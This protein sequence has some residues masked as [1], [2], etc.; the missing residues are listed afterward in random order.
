MGKTKK[1]ILFIVEGITDKTALGAVLDA[2]LSNEKIHFAITE[3]DITTKDDVNASNVIRRINEI[4]KFTQ[5]RYHFKASDLLEVVHLIDT[6]GAFISDDAVIDNPD[7][8]HI[9]CT[10]QDIQT[11]DVGKIIERNQKKLSLV[12][13]LRSKTEINKKSY[14]MFYFS[15]NQEHVLHN[16]ARELPPSEKNALADQFDDLY[17]DTP[18]AFLEFIKS[19]DFAVPGDYAETWNFIEDGTHSLER[20]SNFHLYFG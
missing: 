4:V 20:W 12:K 11:N 14:K 5:E 7:A 19:T 9:Q 16:E 3:G 6:D 15:R 13:L 10:L 17:G 8:T 1:V 18:E 2:I